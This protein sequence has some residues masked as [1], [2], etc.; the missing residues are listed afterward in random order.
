MKVVFLLTGKNNRVGYFAP[1]KPLLEQEDD[2]IISDSGIEES[3]LIE[4]T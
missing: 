1:D 3:G 2:E 4:S